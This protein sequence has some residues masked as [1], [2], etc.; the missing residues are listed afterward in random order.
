MT[1][2]EILTLLRDLESDRVE[3][4]AGLTDVDRVCE[5]ICAFANDLPAHRAPGVVAIG[6]ADD[7][8][9]TD[10]TV[11][12]ELRLSERRRHAALPFDARPVAGSSAGDLDLDRFSG[13]VLPQL[14]APDVVAANQ[15]TT[16]QQL[17]ALRLTDAEGIPTPTGILLCGIDPERWLPGAWTQFL[18]VEGGTLD[19]PIRSEH[20]VAG[21]LP[22]LIAEVEE[23]LRAHL[24]TTVD[25]ADRKTDR[26]R[27][28]VPFD[29]LQQVLRN[30]LI[31]RSYEA[32]SAPVRI[33]WFDDRVEVQSPGGPYGLVDA[34]NF[35][36]PGVTDYRNPNPCDGT[37][38][39][40]LRP[41]VRGWHPGSAGEPRAQ[42]QPTA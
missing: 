10:L 16:A 26:R 20:R 42:R 12:E 1:D 27:P 34:T 11:E 3:R 29:A 14:V 17:A 22:E 40:G 21:S 5:A 2:D 30:A 37:G 31:H 6:L 4:K 9:P 8:R 38:P 25:F 41:A 19:G 28:N 32:T 23:I 35:G 36:R 24:A 33:T 15:R 39:D 13:I 18:R 7:G